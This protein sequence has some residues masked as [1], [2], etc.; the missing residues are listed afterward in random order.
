MSHLHCRMR[1]DPDS[2]SHNI[3]MQKDR[4]NIRTRS[5]PPSRSYILRCCCTSRTYRRPEATL[6]SS[7]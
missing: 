2:R 1:L 3:R 4:R 5:S 6:R 7:C